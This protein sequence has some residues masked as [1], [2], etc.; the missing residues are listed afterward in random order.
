[1]GER[2]VIEKPTQNLEKIWLW[3][4]VVIDGGSSHNILSK[5]FVDRLS[6][7]VHKHR[8]P[9]FVQRLMRCD[10]VLVRH[11]N[12]FTFMLVKTTRYSVVQLVPMNTAYILLGGDWVYNKNRIQMMQNNIYTFVHSRWKNH[13]NKSYQTGTTKED[14]GQQVWR[15]LFKYAMSTTPMQMGLE[16][17]VKLLCN[18]GGMMLSLWADEAKPVAHM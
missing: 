14:I 5:A 12:K 18:S 8:W 7:R 2:T 16:F 3:F 17:E 15:N 13:H 4:Y 6:L 9:Y 1:M 11:T 10:E